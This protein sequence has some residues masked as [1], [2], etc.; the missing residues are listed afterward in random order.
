MSGFLSKYEI[1]K[2][3]HEWLEGFPAEQRFKRALEWESSFC[4]QTGKREAQK[5][6]EDQTHLTHM[7]A[8]DRD[9]QAAQQRAKLRDK[10]ARQG[11]FRSTSKHIWRR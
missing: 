2:S 8:V 4:A 11:D 3:F 1:E 7:Q 10:E 5:Q 6:H 9:R